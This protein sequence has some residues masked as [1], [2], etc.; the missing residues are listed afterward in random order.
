MQNRRVRRRLEQERVRASRECSVEREKRRRTADMATAGPRDAA[1]EGPNFVG[2]TRRGDRGESVGDQPGGGHSMA[3]SIST[4]HAL[5]DIR[6]HNLTTGETVS[7]RNKSGARDLCL[8]CADGDTH[9]P[10][11][12]LYIK[13]KMWQCG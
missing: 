2:W 1:R 10:R 4:L 13:S 9:V 12:V 6:D 8:V 7:L 11:T 3:S 5:Q